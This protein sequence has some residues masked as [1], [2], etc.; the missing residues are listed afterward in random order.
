MALGIPAVASPVGVNRIIVDEKVNGFLCST[1]EE[2]KSALRQLLV[3]KSL[4]ETM[5]LKG[6]SKIERQYSISAQSPEFITLFT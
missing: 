4:R 5:G 2:W 3:N 1:V 6:R